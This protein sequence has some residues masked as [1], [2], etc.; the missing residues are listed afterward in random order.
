MSK[1]SIRDQIRAATIGEKSEFKSK[2]VKYNGIE[3]EIRQPSVKSRKEIMTKAM[4][5]TGTIDFAEFLTFAVLYNTYVPD[6]EELVFEDTD[7]DGLM[8]K[9]TGGFMDQFGA[10]AAELMNVEDGDG[11]KND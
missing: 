2:I 6:T 3:V 9:P 1:Q 7:Y 8:A 4:T 5:D 11:A 10:D